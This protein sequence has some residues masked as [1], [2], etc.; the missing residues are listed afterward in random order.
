LTN[1]TGA[2]IF[3]TIKNEEFITILANKEGYL[4]AQRTFVKDLITHVKETEGNQNTI[5]KTWK[6]EADEIEKEVY[7][8]L[9]K[10]CVVKDNILIFTY[11]N[12]FSSNFEPKVL[13]S[14]KSI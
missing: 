1:N 2:F 11:S 12:L 6:V 14:D 10:E 9:V 5:E 4:L 8:Y 7:I 13:H 3:E